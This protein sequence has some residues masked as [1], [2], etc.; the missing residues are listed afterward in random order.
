MHQ[1]RDHA[2]DLGLLALAAI[3]GINF[4][5]VKAVL[6]VLDPL[7]LNALRFPLAALVL[8]AV[9]ARRPAP[10]IERADRVP[11]AILGILGNVVYQVAFIQGIDATLA[12][13]ASLLLATSPVWTVLLSAA[14]GHEEPKPL[15]FMGS[16]ITLGGMALVVL[17][18][19]RAVG[20]G[21]ETLRGDALMVGASLLWSI[22]TVGS[23]RY[24]RK[25]GAIRVTAWTLWV[26][27]P[28]LVLLGVPSLLSTSWGSVPAWAWGGVAYA[29]VLSVG[30]AYLLWYRGVK[31]LGNSRTALYSNLVPVAALLTAWLWLDEVPTALQAGGAVVILAGISLARWD[32]ARRHAGGPSSLR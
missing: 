12:G 15:V 11:I 21:W 1:R 18:G 13:N 8:A 10:P 27:T 19:G 29:G 24:V 26:G 2:T 9:M 14:L 7:A 5:V 31:R 6:G 30:L 32:G 23:G 4:S 22:Y 28:L 25:Y 3:W 20:W 17:G 16:A